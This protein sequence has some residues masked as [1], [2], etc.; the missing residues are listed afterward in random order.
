MAMALCFSCADESCS[1]LISAA[2]ESHSPLVI[3]VELSLLIFCIPLQGINRD[4]GAD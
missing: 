2:A 3:P 4:K 1:L